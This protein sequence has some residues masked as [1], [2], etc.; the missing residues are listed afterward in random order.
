[1]Q[2]LIVGEDTM[3]ARPMRKFME[4]M[5]H[6]VQFAAT[7][8][9]AIKMS[10]S[11]RFDLLLLNIFLTDGFGY[12]F[13]SRIRTF[14]PNVPII[15]MTEYSTREIESHTRQQG[16]AFYM[17]KPVNLDELKEIVDHLSRK[18]KQINFTLN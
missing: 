3:S 16:V 9:A 17:A 5:Q 8:A 1:M 12:D 18:T 7:G 15:T 2:V 11:Q 10:E 13:I 14:Q 4:Q 6:V